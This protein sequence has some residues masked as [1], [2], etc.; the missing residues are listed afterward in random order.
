MD[1][2]KV[3]VNKLYKL[4]VIKEQDNNWKLYLDN[5]MLTF[6]GFEQDEN[7]LIFLG[8]LATLRFLDMEYFRSTIFNL[9]EMVPKLNLKVNL[10]PTSKE[11]V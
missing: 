10:G 5:L 9:I 8:R 2:Q 7:L 6:L 11:V 3:M 1:T 4:L